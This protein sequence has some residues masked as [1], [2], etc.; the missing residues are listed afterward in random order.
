MTFGFLLMVCRR[1][2]LLGTEASPSDRVCFKWT[3]GLYALGTKGDEF[4]LD[5]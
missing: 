4:L 1:L 5:H 2:P 3:D